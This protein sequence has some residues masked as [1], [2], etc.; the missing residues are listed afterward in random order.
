MTAKSTDK[1]LYLAICDDLRNRIITGDMRP[2]DLLPSEN[3]LAAQ[4]GVSRV[5]ARQSLKYLESEGL[6][7]SRPKRGYF[8]NTPQMDDFTVTYY[9]NL[10]DYRTIFVDTTVGYPTEEVQKALEISAKQK[11]VILPRIRYIEDTAVSYEILYTKYSKAY[12]TIEASMNYA[13]YPDQAF[14]RVTPYSYFVELEIN[15]VSASGEVKDA[16]QC[17]E[18]TALLL[19]RRRIVKQDGEKRAYIL[20]YMLPPYDAITGVSGYFNQA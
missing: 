20:T 11:I 17:P 15:A 8:V 5:T 2:R 16:L 6:I 14:S 19:S 13:S 10:D 1:P 9:K 3:E 7:F 18:G 4:Y 12:P